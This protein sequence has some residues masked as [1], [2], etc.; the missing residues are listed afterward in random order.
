MLSDLPD[1]INATSVRQETDFME[2]MKAIHDALHPDLEE[3]TIPTYLYPYRGSSAFFSKYQQTTR[4][5]H[6]HHQRRAS[7]HH[8]H[9]SHTRPNGRSSSSSKDSQIGRQ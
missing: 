7:N 9:V 6:H 4:N 5:H 8:H 1:A 2:G 3:E